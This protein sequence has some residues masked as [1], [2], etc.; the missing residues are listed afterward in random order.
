MVLGVDGLEELADQRVVHKPEN[1]DF[2]FHYCSSSFIVNFGFIVG[3]EGILLLV[4]GISCYV[5]YSVT[6][7]A[8]CLA[9]LI[10]V[11]FS[12]LFVSGF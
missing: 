6:S 11:Q 9:Y 4:S 3:L 1:L 12:G 8:Q 7:F 5:H 10:V 2:P